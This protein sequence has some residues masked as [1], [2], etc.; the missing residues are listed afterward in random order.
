MREEKT[1]IQ[2]AR[3]KV[4]MNIL[5]AELTESCSLFYVSCNE[6]RRVKP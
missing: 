3:G 2:E 4:S 1:Q 5:I 6:P